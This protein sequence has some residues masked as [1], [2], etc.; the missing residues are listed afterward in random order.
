M[1]NAIS[2][3]VEEYFHATNFDPYVGPARWH[4]MESRAQSSVDR[5]LSVFAENDT[6]GTF[7]VLGCLARRLPQIVR[8]IAAAG[9]EIGSHGYGH[10]LAYHQ[11]QR[12]FA[13]DVLRTKALLEDIIG[14]EVRG[15]RAPN[16]SILD[17]NAWAYDALVSAGYRYDS[18]LYP[19]RHPRYSNRDKP[20]VPFKL[21]RP[22]GELLIFPLATS[23]F[24]LL[25]SEFR[26]GVAGG[27]YWRFF[28][29]EMIRWCLSRAANQERLPINC[30]FHPWELDPDQP[31]IQSMPWLTRLRHYGGTRQ[32][33]GKLRYFLRS[34]TFTPIWP[35]LSDLFPQDT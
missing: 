9:H 23:A 8:Q 34:F 31:V 33:E 10:R 2:V 19:V 25:G 22:S 26:L 16:F 18:S 21:E 15:Y 4:S 17:G 12:A 7:F 27:A 13:R 11:N 14:H 6:K 28:P 1:L 32:F 20:R 24:H 35:I 29:K 30:Y 3:D 5:T